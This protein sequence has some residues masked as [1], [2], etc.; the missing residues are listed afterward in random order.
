MS[1]DSTKI[2]QTKVIVTA[3]RGFTLIEIVIAMAILTFLSLFTAQSIERATRDK[4]KVQ[5]QIDK[6]ASVRD[7]LRVMERDINLAFNWRDIRIELYNLAQDKRR[8]INSQGPQGPQDPRSPQPP[9]PPQN[10]PPPENPNQP[11]YSK[12]TEKIMTHFLGEK[13]ALSFTSISNIRMMEDE[14][15]SSQAEIGY[16]LKPC[17][18]RSTQEQSSNC[19]W[20]RVSNFIHD[21]ITKEGQETVILENVVELTFKYLGPGFDGEWTDTWFTN[22]R[23]EDRTRNVFPF[24]VEITLEVRDTNAKEKDKT[25]RMTRVAGLRNPNNPIKETKP[26]DQPDNSP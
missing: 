19:L 23:G 25:L 18:R 1:Q 3:C 12:K 20:R 14:P 4:V 6:N 5:K 10:P 13:D 24:A 8:Q 16:H 2:F 7:A 11:D 17:R 15:M 9:N 22:E 21:D 26:G